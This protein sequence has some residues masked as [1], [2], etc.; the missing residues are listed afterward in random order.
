MPKP[1]PIRRPRLGGRVA[2]WLLALTLVLPFA[3]HVNAPVLRTAASLDRI[4]HIVIIMQENRTFDHYFGTFPGAA[5]I[6]VDS[7]G[8][9]TVCIPTKTVG[10][11]ARPY[12][13]PNLRNTG[14]PHM[15]A[16][17]LADIH[18]GK[19]DGFVRQ[20]STAGTEVLGFHDQRELPFY[21]SMAQQYMLQDHLFAPSLGW[22]P[23]THSDMVSGW[24]AT[25][26]DV[27]DPMSCVS[28]LGPM[29][30]DNSPHPGGEFAWTDI[31]YLLHAAGVK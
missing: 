29:D 18:G 30:S 23:T 14:G 21:W 6:P 11:C 8:H 16:S 10:V 24:A 4:Q 5:G 27:N 25:C 26:S 31:T 2:G 15:L 22:S 20:A 28:N 17:A 13:N 3:V 7:N 9:F 12:H 1:P 19:M